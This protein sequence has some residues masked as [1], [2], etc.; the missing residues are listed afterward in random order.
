M[1]KKDRSNNFATTCREDVRFEEVVEEA[2]KKMREAVSANTSYEVVRSGG[3]IIIRRA[4][5]FATSR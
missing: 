5:K 1:T 2:L 3:E 4:G